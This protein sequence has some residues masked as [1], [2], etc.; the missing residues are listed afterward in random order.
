MNIKKIGL[1]ALAASL[2]SVSAYAGEMSVAGGA[3][4]TIKNN[5]GTDGGKQ[6][7]MGNQLTFTGGGEL[8]NGLNVALSFVLDHGD[9]VASGFDSHSLTISSDSLGSISIAGDGTGNAQS[10]LDT[11]AAGD[12]WDNGF[13]HGAAV[14]YVGMG[15]SDATNNKSVNYTLPT[16]M[17]DLAVAVSYL[18]LIHI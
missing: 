1:T 14:A 15:G 6:I 10:A 8:D 3:S 9:N 18:S 4:A 17:D 11:T 5:S 16:I 7:T 2:V 12:I 13:T